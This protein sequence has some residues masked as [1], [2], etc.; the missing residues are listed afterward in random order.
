M[1]DARDTKTRPPPRLE[2]PKNRR[3]SPRGERS[4]RRPVQAEAVRGLAGETERF[5]DATTGT[6]AD[7]GDA[8]R[9]RRGRR[10]THDAGIIGEEPRDEDAASRTPRPVFARPRY[11]WIA[12]NA[13]RSCLRGRSGDGR[14]ASVHARATL[15]QH[16]G[17]PSSSC[18]RETVHSR[19]ATCRLIRALHELSLLPEK[20]TNE[21]SRDICC[22][23]ESLAVCLCY[24][25]V[26]SSGRIIPYLRV[27]CGGISRVIV[28]WGRHVFERREEAVEPQAALARGPRRVCSLDSPKPTT[29][30]GSKTPRS[31]PKRTMCTASASRMPSLASSSRTNTANRSVMPCGTSSDGT[32]DVRFVTLTAASVRSDRPVAAA[33]RRRQ[34]FV[35]P[36]RRGADTRNAA[37][38][39]RRRCS[40]RATRSRTSWSVR[41]TV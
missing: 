27:R 11:R 8:H 30:P 31:S 18:A 10:K 24:C 20:W 12:A 9:T 23:C 2:W 14:G 5:A 33:G 19:A 29:T 1:S 13:R 39:P 4:R 41:T 7:R 21:T 32:V 38:P 16:C 26:A 15:R 28:L 34:R 22:V 6:I 37:T 36:D 17:R 40:M 35:V 25:S 3:R